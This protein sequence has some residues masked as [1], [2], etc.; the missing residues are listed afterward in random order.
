MHSKRPVYVLSALCA[1]IVAITLTLFE[2]HEKVDRYIARENNSYSIWNDYEYSTYENQSAPLGIVQEY[3]WTITDTPQ[4]N[5]CLAFYLVHQWAEIYID[6]ELLFHLYSNED[7]FFTQT[8]GSDW[9][10]AYLNASDVNREIRILIYPIYETSINRTLTIY[11]GSLNSVIADVIDS[12][13]YTII[14]GI[15][16][17]M[18][19]IAFII[20]VLINIK[21]HDMDRSIAS[22]GFFSIFTGAWKIFD[23]ELMPFLFEDSTLLFSAIANIAITLMLLAFIIYIRNQFSKNVYLF[24]NCVCI[25]GL[26][27]CII[28]CMLQLFGIADLRQTLTACH[29]MIVID[30]I[31]IFITLIWEAVHHRL[32]PKLK[33]TSLC[34]ILCSLGAI[35]DLLLY[36]LSGASGNMMLCLFA[37]LLYVILMGNIAVKEALV[38]IQRGKEAKR[39]QHLAIHDQMTGLYNRAYWAEYIKE[40]EH[41]HNNCFIIMLDINNLKQCNDTLGHDAGDQ[42]LINSANLIK[43][44]FSIS[45][46]P[47]RMGGDEFCVILNT[48]SEIICTKYLNQLLAAVEHFNTEH[49]EEYP[50]QIAYGYAQFEDIL[51]YDLGDTLRRAD[52]NMYKKKIEMKKT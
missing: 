41:N 25:I 35:I 39:Y 18:I 27:F 21:N 10:K 13:L 29:V 51:D 15:I 44:T 50:I 52:K 23:S 7:N 38:L 28:I 2:H 17:I 26:I 46:I 12:N 30:I 31:S 20:F 36:Y 5:T 42:L 11:Y 1:V 40:P 48:T 19:G 24:W 3:R 6:D 37:F 32:T 8:I 16:S 43:D 34:F 45:G 49:P 9:A 14:F 47:I 22:L 33:M 4:Q